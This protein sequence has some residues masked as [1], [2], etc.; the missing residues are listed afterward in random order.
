M[1]R[2]DFVRGQVTDVSAP[3]ALG[4]LNNRWA[5]AAAGD[6]TS[7]VDVLNY[8][9]TLEYLESAFYQKGNAAGLLSGDEKTYLEKIG[10]DEA[11][12]VTAITATI[13]GISAGLRNTG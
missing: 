2:R 1:S 9:L 8:A 4:A 11:F 10:S 3:L 13:N 12:H 6:F 7:D 5:W